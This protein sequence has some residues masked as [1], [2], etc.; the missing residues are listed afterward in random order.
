MPVQRQR[1]GSQECF[2]RVEVKFR[3]EV[4]Y[5]RKRSDL[6]DFFDI[7][8]NLGKNTPQSTF[9]KATY[10][11]RRWPLEGQLSLG[12]RLSR[13]CPFQR[14][15]RRNIGVS[16]NASG[17]DEEPQHVEVLELHLLIDNCR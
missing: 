12:M 13:L 6:L 11:K 15:E 2:C 3:R 10:V 9:L 1:W 7:L 16:P 5:L 4:L 17:S 8:P 14:E